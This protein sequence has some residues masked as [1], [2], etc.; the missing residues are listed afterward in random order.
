MSEQVS[1]EKE[2]SEMSDDEL[3]ELVRKLRKSRI[4]MKPTSKKAK[5]QKKVSRKAA[6]KAKSIVQELSKDEL[7][8]FLEEV[9]D[10]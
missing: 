2:I 5:A 1:V 10:G 8:K 6:S 3:R 7:Q 4:L 9:G